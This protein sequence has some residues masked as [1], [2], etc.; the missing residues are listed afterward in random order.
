MQSLMTAQEVREY[1]KVSRS[2]LTRLLDAGLP[3][4][5]SGRLRRF[6]KETLLQWYSENT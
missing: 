2:T 1:L 5:G 3:H 6:H 4:I